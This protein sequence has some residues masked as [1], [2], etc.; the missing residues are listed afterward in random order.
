[1]FNKIN[2]DIKKNIFVDLSNSI[3]FE[4]ITNGRLGAISV[5]YKNNLIPIV[6][7]TTI[8][9]NSVQIFPPC[10]YEIINEIKKHFNNI[11][12]NNALIEIYNFKYTNMNFHSDQDLDLEDDSQICLF[13]CYNNSET[14][15]IRQLI[16]KEK[17]N[18]YNTE[19]ILLNHNSAV[20]FS[21][22]TNKKYLHKIILNKI[23]SN[24]EWLGITFR[25]SK[26]FIK[27]INEI[28][29]FYKINKLLTLANDIEKKQFFQLKKLENINCDFNYYQIDFTISE[30][31]LIKPTF[32]K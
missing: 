15:D 25:L 4:Q 19:T 24:D 13:S 10:F 8:Y 23:Q 12:F 18:K 30:S 11:D 27:F 3:V 1:M 31:D 14:L 7:T 26:T 9:K 22:D 21:T 2:I 17:G 20:I 5:N 6:R 32:I 16:V 28:P 29:Y